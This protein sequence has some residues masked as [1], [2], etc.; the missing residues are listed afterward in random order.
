MY[1]SNTLLKMQQRV[2]GLLLVTLAT[3]GLG[4]TPYSTVYYFFKSPF[5]SLVKHQGEKSNLTPKVPNCSVQ[6]TLKVL[7]Y[8]SDPVFFFQTFYQTA[9]SCYKDGHTI[10]C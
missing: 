9:K 6:K 1:I 5:N 4:P 2:V 10:V 7:A 8:T 3:L